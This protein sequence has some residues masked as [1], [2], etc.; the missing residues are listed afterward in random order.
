[1]TRGYSPQ[2]V[3]SGLA[4]AKGLENGR[5]TEEEDEEREIYSLGQ[6]NL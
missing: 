3:Y 2:T 6:V 1:M 4:P 5:K